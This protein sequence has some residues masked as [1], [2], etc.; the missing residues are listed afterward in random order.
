MEEIKVQVNDKYGS[1]CIKD[2]IVSKPSNDRKPEGFVEIYE[3]KDGKK[4][5]VGKHNLVIFQARE[6]IAEKIFNTNNVNTPTSPS[7]FICWFGLGEGGAPV[8]DPLNPTAPLSTDTDLDTEVPI[9]ATDV[10]CGDLRSGNYYKHPLDSI[11][12]Q[13]DA[14]N[15]DKWLIVKV[16]T[17]IGTDDG[18]GSG[19]QILNEAGLFTAASSSGSYSGDFFLFSRVTFP[20][21]VKDTS[22]Q[23]VFMWYIYF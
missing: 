9:N 14:A 15:S 12:F 21:I 2:A 19:S 6:W 18:N 1:N 17:T 10:A 4:K 13:Q 20:S 7:E 3:I 5:L 23:L 11:E 22:R 16:T 8:G